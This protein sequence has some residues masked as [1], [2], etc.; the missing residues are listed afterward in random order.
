MIDRVYQALRPL[1]YPA[2]WEKRPKL[3]TK[4]VIS[5]HFFGEG[6]Q[7]YGNGEVLVY[8]GKLQVDIFSKTDYSGAVRAVRDAL[9]ADGFRFEE[10]WDDV[11]DLDNTTELY[12]KVMIFNYAER[13][14]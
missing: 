13:E 7:F 2:L 14:K 1:G 12:H 11:E 10:A 9:T 3:T 5:F 4:P 6:G 8:G